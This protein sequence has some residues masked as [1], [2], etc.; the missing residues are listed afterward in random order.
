MFLQISG[1]NLPELWFNCLAH[2]CTSERSVYY[3]PSVY[4]RRLYGYTTGV[5]F[6]KTIME[7]D[8]YR[9]SGYSK[10]M[11]LSSLRTSYYSEKVQ[12]QHKLLKSI[13]RKLQPRQSR[14]LISFS[15]PAFD[16]SSRLKCLDSLYIHK[17]SMTSYEALI[18]FRATEI[19]PKMFMDLVFL[20]EILKTFNEERVKCIQFSL[21][22]TSGFINMFNAPLCAM[23]LRKYGITA[24][25]W[26]SAFKD[27]LKVWDE[28]FRDP[29]SLED[30]K[31]TFIQRIVKRTHRIM[32]EDGIDISI[33]LKN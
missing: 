16:D 27:S 28:K 14:G 8:F 10:D 11:K 17:E 30:I 29:K 1:D 4:C 26:N 18:I 13:I 23:F 15:E 20:E 21:F 22:I 7:K 33:L 5:H 25:S 32:E 3:N 6:N 24:G 19:Y 12:K 2:L 31:M 9:Y